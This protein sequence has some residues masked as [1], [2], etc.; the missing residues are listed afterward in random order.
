MKTSTQSSLAMTGPKPL[1]KSLKKVGS[2]A[3]SFQNVKSLC[4]TRFLILSRF[5]V[6]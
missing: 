6:S 3:T 4:L 5:P 1:I 2:Q